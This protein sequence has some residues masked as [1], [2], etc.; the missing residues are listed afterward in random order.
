MFIDYHMPGM[1]G[2]Q[3]LRFIQDNENECKESMKLIVTADANIPADV[4]KEILSM[5]DEILSKGLTSAD[6][7]KIIRSISLRSV[8]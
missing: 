1:D 6:I 7:K 4:K 5:A 2:L 8:C 3:F